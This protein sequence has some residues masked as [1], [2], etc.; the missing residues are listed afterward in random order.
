M[1]DESDGWWTDVVVVT[2][3]WLTLAANHWRTFVLLLVLPSDTNIVCL[4]RFFLPFVVFLLVY[5]SLCGHCSGVVFMA[6]V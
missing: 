6:L 1:G 3:F 2:V 5:Y 4:H